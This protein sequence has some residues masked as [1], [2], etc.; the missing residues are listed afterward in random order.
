MCTRGGDGASGGRPHT[1]VVVPLGQ[2]GLGSHMGVTG[3]GN[4]S[5]FPLWPPFI[6]SNTLKGIFV[7]QSPLT[8]EETG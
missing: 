2:L 1:R 8:K 3:V 4:T 7:Y 5:A 6:H